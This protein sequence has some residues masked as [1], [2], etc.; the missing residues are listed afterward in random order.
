MA[1]ATD[2]PAPTV[3]DD[4]DTAAAP[5]ALFFPAN[6]SLLPEAWTGLGFGLGHDGSSNSWTPAPT[7]SFDHHGNSFPHSLDPTMRLAPGDAFSPTALFCHDNFIVGM[8]APFGQ[9]ICVRCGNELAAANST[10]WSADTRDPNPLGYPSMASFPSPDPSP[11]R[12]ASLSHPDTWQA[13][14]P[15]HSMYPFNNR[16]ETPNKAMERGI[17]QRRDSGPSH[18]S[19]RQQE[20]EPTH[21]EWRS[22]A[23]GV[24]V[25]SPTSPLSPR[26]WTAELGGGDMWTSVATKERNRLSATRYRERTHK[27]TK[28]LEAESQHNEI[29]NR[30]LR[31]CFDELREEVLA[32]KTEIL[33][34]SNCNCPLMRHYMAA[35]AQKIVVSMVDSGHQAM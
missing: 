35:E 14:L 32:L 26:S 13:R 27:A 34:Q 28:N 31:A 3:D 4:D 6:P 20:E 11:S 33:R 25:M 24:A 22:H 8:P 12:I 16:E 10:F 17:G 18:S 7:F 1:A 30:S 21:S 2:A 23:H 5:V 29:H 19:M 9:N 15:A